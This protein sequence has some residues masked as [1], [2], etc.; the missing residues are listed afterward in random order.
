MF[1][2]SIVALSSGVLT[3]SVLFPFGGTNYAKASEIENPPQVTESLATTLTI[4]EYDFSSNVL[5]L[6]GTQLNEN[7]NED[8]NEIQSRGIKKWITTQALKGTA[9]ALRSGGS[10]I[11]TVA[12]QLTKSEAKIFTKHTNTIANALEDLVRR[13][14]VVED[15]IMDTVASALMNVG[16]KS[17]TARTIANIFTFFAF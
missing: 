12:S 5:P 3:A 16:V 8:K 7:E 10:V 9:K 17:S 4:I 6:D 15:A 14:D 2:K 13:G 11:N 1:K